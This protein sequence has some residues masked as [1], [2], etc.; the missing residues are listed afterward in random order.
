MA[1]SAYQQAMEDGFN[2]TLQT[3]NN[4]TNG[5]AGY[6]YLQCQT[7]AVPVIN[8]PSAYCLVPGG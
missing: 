3:A 2:G 6:W 5:S 8:F 4:I 1:A 7:T